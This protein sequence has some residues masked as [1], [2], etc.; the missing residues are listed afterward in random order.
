MTAD[1]AP[2]GYGLGVDLGT[3]RTAAAVRVDGRLEVVRL[4]AHRHEIPSLIYVRADGEILVGDAAERRG[5]SDPERLAR[6][7][8]RRVGDQIKLNLGGTEYAAPTLMAMLLSDVIDTVSDRQQCAPDAIT[9][10]HPANWTAFKR[11]RLA[12]AF[13]AAGLT[14]I[15]F[16]SEPEAIAV[17]YAAGERVQPDEIVAVYD[18]GGGTFDTAILRKTATGFEV[19]GEPKGVDD[20]GGIDFDEEVYAHVAA[21]LDG[22]I[23]S[24]DLDDE[25]VVEA[26]TRLRA[27]CLA[28]KEALSFDTDVMIPVALPGLHTRVRLNRSEFEARIAPRLDETVEAMRGALRSAATTPAE[29]KCV[30]LAGGSSRIPLVGQL[31]TTAFDRPTVRDPHPEHSV[32]LGAALLTGKPPAD[33]PAPAV[34]APAPAPPTPTTPEPAPPVPALPVPV[35]VTAAPEPSVRASARS[36]AP[37][38]VSAPAPGAGHFAAGR[39]TVPAAG[40]AADEPDVTYRHRERRARWQEAIRPDRA[41]AARTSPRLRWLIA[42][43][44]VL[45]VSGGVYY[46]TR[47]D[48]NRPQAGAADA[49]TVSA[50]TGPAGSPS[51]RVSQ[52]SSKVRP[53]KGDSGGGRGS[54]PQ[55][56]QRQLPNVVDRSLAEARALLAEAGFRPPDVIE[57]HRDGVDDGTVIDMKPNPGT[58]YALDK[59]ITLTVSVPVPATEEPTDPAPAPAP[60]PDGG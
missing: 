3:T 45:A 30:L 8:K 39:A 34:A 24:L 6:E 53:K 35:P 40:P 54:Q 5:A 21:T 25:G 31:L 27:D 15:L 44:A 57:D 37:T 28:G 58:L 41:A 48:K 56:Q 16:R 51:A 38:S 18:L 1:P 2:P 10:T 47:P 23:D 55:P 49:P 20:L 26:L 22:A 50:T 14:G 9:V 29:L 7:F 12:E 59:S 36:V 46:E 42:V 17:Q 19:L 32:A 52:A 43:L 4:G 11:D 13:R 60:S 33:A